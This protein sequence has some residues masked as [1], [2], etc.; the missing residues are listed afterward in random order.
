[1]THVVGSLLSVPAG[2]GFGGQGTITDSVTCQ[3][4]I[5][6]APGGDSF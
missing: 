2:Q 6:A 3:G 1:M 4:T 5:A